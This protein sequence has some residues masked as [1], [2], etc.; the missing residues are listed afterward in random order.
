MPYRLMV[1]GEVREA[2]AGKQAGRPGC[3]A[4][5]VEGAACSFLLWSGSHAELPAPGF[6][7]C[8]FQ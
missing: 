4:W 5:L 3:R 2:C 7:L 1:L 6:C 8:I